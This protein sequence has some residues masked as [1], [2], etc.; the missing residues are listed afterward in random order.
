MS[1]ETVCNIEDLPNNAGIAALIEGQQI[2]IFNISGELYAIENFDPVG[3]ANVLSR[4][5]LGLIKGE[6]CVA[7]P[8]YKQHFSL[9]TGQCL[10]EAVSVK[11]YAIR[12]VDGSVEIDKSSLQ[13]QA[14]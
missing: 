4:G 14:A 13:R 8:L 12:C 10:E 9:T 6:L 11:C 1:W 7:S 2:A 5:I 3:K